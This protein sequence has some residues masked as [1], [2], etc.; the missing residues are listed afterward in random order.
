MDETSKRVQDELS[1][2]RENGLVLPKH[3]Y[4]AIND[5]GDAVKVSREVY[6]H[7]G[8]NLDGLEA[9]LGR[10]I[11]S[12]DIGSKEVKKIEEENAALTRAM[13]NKRVNSRRLQRTSSIGGST[14][15]GG[16]A[17][18]A[19]PRFYDPLEYWDLSG[20]PWNVADE[21]HRHKLHKW[22]RLYYATHYLVPCLIDIYTRFP[23]IGADL[24]CKD[25][26][27]ESVYEDIFFG[28]LN[29]P[30]FLVNVGREFFLVG[31]AFPLGSF[32]ENLGIWD[33]EELIN[34]EDVVI[35]NFPFLDTTQLKIVPPDYLKRIAQNKT[36]VREWVMLRENYSDLI[37][38]LLKGEHIPVS[39]VMMRQIANKLNSWDDHGTP[40]LLRGLSTLIYEEKL[41]ASQEAIAE[42]LYSPFIL[43][44]LGI[45]DMGDGL[46]PWIPTPEELESVRDDLDLALASDFRVMVHHFG[47]ELSSV[48]GREQMPRLGDDFDRV[49]RRLLQV[50][51]ISP[52]LLQAGTNSQPYASSALQAEFMNQMLKTYQD[53]LKAHF[54]ERALVVAEA[55]GHYDYEQKGSKRI[56]IMEDQ[57]V[58]DEE[59][60]ERIERVHKL[61][62]PTLNFSSFD[63]R[64]DATERQFLMD[65]RNMGVPIPNE[66]LLIGVDWDYREK[67]RL[68]NEEIKE[69]TILQQETKMETYIALAIKGLPI[70][71]ELKAEVESVLMPEQAS[72]GAGGPGGSPGGQPPQ[73]GQGGSQ[74]SPQ[75]GP[76]G[77]GFPIMMPPPPPG[78]GGDNN[79]P[80]GGGTPAIA[81][82]NPQ[83][84]TVPEVSNE[85]RPG[86]TYN[87]S[88]S[89]KT[90]LASTNKTLDKFLESHEEL[91]MAFGDYLIS[92]HENIDSLE[93]SDLTRYYEEWPRFASVFENK[94][95]DELIARM[96][97][98]QAEKKVSA[99]IEKNDNDE[100]SLKEN[101]E[102]IKDERGEYILESRKKNNPRFE[103]KEG[104]KYSIV[105]TL[106]GMESYDDNTE[107]TESERKS[108]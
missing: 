108:A 37:P 53:V 57:V 29:Y 55:Q 8:R 16:D 52:G 39:S 15:M 13:G 96:V 71:F 73:G 56:P 86:L 44:K 93:E 69:Q 6:D 46:P 80:S 88:N 75:G 24:E 26:K 81:P 101:Q 40:M 87:T 25:K 107:Q 59:G 66:E 14:P 68:S 30:E 10:K 7:A 47:L 83:R 102:L 79:A 38:Y 78:I 4:R 85:R 74:G 58:Y 48:F 2:L 34:P 100:W 20:L 36:P 62:V 31:E 91:G 63:L 77:G 94:I 32:N 54:R 76:Q 5:Y 9:R 35:D 33:H 28:T 95:K 104:K 67:V 97:D 51:G 43:A 82:N 70:P 72:Q 84:G 65:L 92:R 21:G 17:Y 60:N 99:I 64:D 42:R 89:G 105:D 12:D 11:T 50:F 27:L 106:S 41:R 61:L 49:E 19:V 22:L 23:L 90:R 18:N 103:V 1:R 45:M 98:Q 3:P